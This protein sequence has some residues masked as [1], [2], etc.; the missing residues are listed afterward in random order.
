MP[1]STGPSAGGVS[2]GVSGGG[3]RGRRLA[4][5]PLAAGRLDQLDRTG[6]G[7]AVRQAAARI[8]EWVPKG[9]HF[10]WE[11]AFR[12]KGKFPASMSKPDARRL[13]A[14]LLAT[15]PLTVHGNRREGRACPDQLVV[16]AEAADAVGTRG[17]RRVRIVIV[18]DDAGY[19]VENAFPVRSR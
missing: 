11:R 3:G 1:T 2:G 19:A 10:G 5:S 4:E 6:Y 15:A 17:Q 8:T 7:E 12:N 14:A 9:V 13:V 16:I 18:R